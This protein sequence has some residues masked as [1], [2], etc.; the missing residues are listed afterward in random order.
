MVSLYINTQNITIRFAQV[1]DLTSVCDLDRMVTYEYFKPLYQEHFTHFEL[2]CNPDPFLEKE[3]AADVTDFKQL[4]T[5]NAN[6]ILI[7]LDVERIVGILIFHQES[8][9]LELDL[10]L[11]DEQ[12][13]KQGIGK[14]LVDAMLAANQDATHCNVYVIRGNHPALKFY[15]KLGFINLGIPHKEKQN[16]YG[17]SYADMYWHYEL[18]IN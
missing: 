17:I 8:T 3:L 10:L 13:R 2:G 12:Y 7:A 4:L 16:I 9:S 1:A 5:S 6:H 11:I 18:R 15:E 14:K